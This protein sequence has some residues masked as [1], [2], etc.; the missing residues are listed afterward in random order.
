MAC[1]PVWYSSSN[2][3]AVSRS[4]AGM[5][6]SSNSFRR[7]EGPTPSCSSSLPAAATASRWASGL[8]SVRPSAIT[9][10][11]LP[12]ARNGWKR[13]AMALGVVQGDGGSS[14][15]GVED[16]LVCGRRESSQEVAARLRGHWRGICGRLVKLGVSGRNV[17][18]GTQ[19]LF[20]AWGGGAA[21]LQIERASDRRPLRTNLFPK[22]GNLRIE[23]MHC[24]CSDAAK[25]NLKTRGLTRSIEAAGS[26]ANGLEI[27]GTP[28]GGGEGRRTLATSSRRLVERVSS[29]F[30]Y[31]RYG[32]RPCM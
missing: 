4:H 26:T 22:I 11:P 3:S 16:R 32:R 24:F 28:V 21:D 23:L 19:E 20:A 1:G 14:T 6:P 17:A 29:R 31:G 27:E 12:L 9:G 2:T 13:G 5:R 7:L 18:R 30:D 10:Q 8:R 25:N 15:A